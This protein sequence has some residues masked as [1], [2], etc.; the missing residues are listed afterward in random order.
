MSIDRLAAFSI[1]GAGGNP[2]GV[3]LCE[4]LPPADEMQRI[5]HEVGYSETVFAEPNQDGWRVRYFAPAMEVPFCGHATIALGAVLAR[6]KGDGIFVLQ[7]N[8]GSVTVEGKAGASLSATLQSPPTRSMS[9]PRD[10]LGAALELFSLAHGDLDQGLPPAIVEAGA[11]HLVLGLKRRERLSTMEYEF[12]AGA[13]LMRAHGFA[14]IALV[15]A[16]THIRFHARNAFAAGGVK[17]DPATGA[18]AAA[19]GGYLRDIGWKHA[20]RIEIIQGEDM[21]QPC[22]LVVE[23]PAQTGSS[24]RLSG[25]ARLL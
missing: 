22:R 19:L 8:E 14:T 21:G 2:A 7:L 23:I 16:E 1:A 20:G 15:Q 24:V 13:A 4:V 3:M 11:R 6:S 17:E 5:A 9:C 25:E 18:A 10:L 12:D